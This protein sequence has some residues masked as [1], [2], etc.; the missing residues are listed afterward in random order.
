MVSFLSG[1]FQRHQT[2]SEVAR[3][4]EIVRAWQFYEWRLGIGQRPLV[5]EPGEPDDNRQI[6]YARNIVDKGAAF[7]FGKGVGIQVGGAQDDPGDEFLKNIWP[8][9]Q[10][11][12]DLLNAAVNGGVFGDAYFRIGLENGTPRVILLDPLSVDAEWSGTDYSLVQRWTLTHN[13]M[14]NGRPAVLTERIDRAGAGWVIRESI[15]DGGAET[16]RREIAWNYPFAPVFHCQNWPLPNEFYGRADLSP[17]VLHLIENLWRVDSQINRQ[18]RLHGFPKPVITGAN[19][20]DV[21]LESRKVLFLPKPGQKIEM[22][23]MSREL[24]AAFQDRKN[25]REALSEVT[26]VPE[27]ATGKVENVGQLSSLALKILYGPLLERTATKRLL[28]GDMIVRLC[29][30]LLEMGGFA[31]QPVT[32]SWPDPLPGDDEAQTNRLQTH[33]AMGVASRRTLAEKLGYDW[34]TELARM[35]EERAADTDRRMQALNFGE[36]V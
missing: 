26:Q 13:I 29:R 35:N 21:N 15:S 11:A 2:E 33:Q 22:L 7:L 30:A 28:Y 31:G 25:L 19:K 36:S 9:A 8:P 23:E 16:V 34:E 20:A 1:F 3:R 32:L 6:N 27:I 14:E 12:L 18:V 10:R 17:D 4:T 5:V 24:Q